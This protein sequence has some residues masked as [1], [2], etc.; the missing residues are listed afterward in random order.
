[1]QKVL[2]RQVDVGCVLDGELVVW[3]GAGPDFDALQ[4]RMVQ[5]RRDGRTRFAPAQRA[6]FIVF[7][8]LAIDSVDIRPRAEQPGV[9]GWSRSPRTGS[10]IRTR[11]FAGG[12]VSTGRVL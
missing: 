7:D 3:T 10:L 6:S 1:V 8:V 9:A 12:K 5:H 2:A 4:H 11:Q